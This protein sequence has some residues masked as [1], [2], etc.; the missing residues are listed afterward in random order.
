MDNLNLPTGEEAGSPFFR[1]WAVFVLRR[2]WLLLALTAVVTGVAMATIAAKLEKD[3]SVEAFSKDGAASTQLLERY[4]D[5]FGRD[6][7]FLL[8]IEGD[9]FSVSYLARLQALE[10]EIAA[11]DMD[12]S[13]LGERRADRQRQRGRAPPDPAATAAPSRAVPSQELAASDDLAG[14]DD[15]DADFGDL[16]ADAG[17]G[18]EAGGS[19]IDEVTSLLSVRRTRAT[20]DGGIDVG[21]L[22]ER[23]PETEAEVAELRR[24]V[25]GDPASGVGPDPMLVGQVVDAAGRHT[26][27]LVRMQFMSQ[28]DSERVTGVMREIVSRHEGPDFRIHVAGSPALESELNHLMIT[29]MVRMFGLSFLILMS[30][31]FFMF[32]HP[33][34]A[35]A[36]VCVV[37]LSAI[38]AF[39]FMAAVGIPMTMISQILPA[40]LICVGVADAVHLQSVYRQERAAGS[41]NHDAIIHAVASTGMPVLFTSMTTAIGLLSFRFASVKA[42]GEMGTTGALG[43]SMAFL[44]TVVLLPILLSFNRTSLMGALAS[45]RGPDLVDRFLTACVAL[46]GSGRRV[47][48]GRV[49]NPNARRRRTLAAALVLTLVAGYGASK[50]RVWHNPVSWMPTETP[51]SQAI[52]VADSHMGG[53]ATINLLIEAN[54]ASGVKDVRLM[55]GLEKLET[56]IKSYRMPG[57]KRLL[58]GTSISVVDVVREANQALLGGDRAHRRVPDTQAEV[59]DRFVAFENAG[60]EQMKRLMTIDAS[61]AQMTVRARWMDATSYIPFAAHIEA[62]AEEHIPSSV[63]TVHPTGTIY[64][65]LWTVGSML[66]DLIR[67]FAVAFVVITILMAFLLKSWKLGLVAMVP[68]LLPIVFIMGLMG[69]VDIPIDMANLM[70]ASIALGIAVDDTIHF[71]HHFRIHFEDHG[72][73]DGAI[74][75]SMKHS[76]RALVVTSIILCAGFF[77]FMGGSMLSIQRFGLLIG[78]TVIM[79]LLVDLVLTP[80]LLRTVYTPLPPTVAPAPPDLGESHDPPVLE[81][82]V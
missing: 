70:I 61:V 23:L 35:L 43:V 27:M 28:P 29:D 41:E 21:E 37:V 53:T 63:A 6:D 20:P 66:Y 42:I 18:D 74:A 51:I 79:A 45:T 56:H 22:V 12:I 55:K 46:S 16:D 1:A 7:A 67:S 5:E 75:H 8:I 32:R 30:V 31:L 82:L 78:L 19:I 72:D 44:H 71:V 81:S 2:R 76:G 34:G 24:E 77:V 10:D 3:M 14:F 39:G 15:L 73:V 80:A 25:L 40:F 49:P 48:G 33:I 4:R 54:G 9:V 57:E 58:V 65:L 36:P 62:G 50:L 13:S 69:Y 60:P 68:N 47:V 38:W 52:R 17:W 64:T 11:L 59:N 26:G